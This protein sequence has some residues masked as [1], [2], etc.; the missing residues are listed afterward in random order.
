MKPTLDPCV[1][2]QR[3]YESVSPA[4]PFTASSIAEAEIW[5]EKARPKLQQLIGDF[6]DLGGPVPS[7]LIEERRFSGYTRR[8]LELELRPGLLA[9]AYYL[10][11]DGCSG[12][13][14]A[15]L[16]VPGHSR[17]VDE[18][19]GGTN[20]EGDPL[21]YALQCARAGLVTLALEQMAFGYR[22]DAASIAQSPD[23]GTACQVPSGAAL[24]LGRT[25]LG[26]RVFD[27]RRALDWLAAQPEVD[28]SRIGMT[29]ISG[30]GTVTF[31][32][33]CLDTRLKAVL[34]SGYFNTYRGSVYS[35][36]HCID[37]FIPG[38]LRWFEMPDLAGLLAPRYAFFKQGA[39]DPIFPLATFREAVEKAERIYSVFGVPE[40]IGS[41]VFP[42]GHE[43][44]GSQGVP[45][46]ANVL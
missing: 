46:L 21:D 10:V 41:H 19:V 33:G 39:D 1:F 4:L 14:P 38:V 25:M 5:Q 13:Y 40:R 22:R 3:E 7:R 23:G 11:P 42:G 2:F 44:N 34:V 16:A 24:L 37:N 20:G 31:Y 29:G 43:W 35:I 18:L 28:P 9:I 32:T 8:L 30:G 17:S 45:W 26:Y 15:V 36:W 12:R 27:A 6:P